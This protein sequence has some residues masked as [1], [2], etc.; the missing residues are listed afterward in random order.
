VSKSIGHLERMDLVARTPDP[1]GR[2]ERYAVIDD[3]WSRAWRTDTGA[4]AK[5]AEAARRGTEI[6]GAGTP[7][8]ARLAKMARFFGWLSAQMGDSTIGEP[9]VISVMLAVPDPA[10]AARWYAQALGATEVWNRGS[11][12]GLTVGG[13]PFSLGRPENDGWDTPAAA[14]TRTTRIEVLVDNP[15]AVIERAVAAGADGRGIVHRP[16]GFLDPYGHLWTV[17]DRSLRSVR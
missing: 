1:G 14:G 4:H 17:G 13:A 16:G 12:I 5:V 3:V 11:A 6:L 9:V 8:G 2:R 10:A 15:D 7:A